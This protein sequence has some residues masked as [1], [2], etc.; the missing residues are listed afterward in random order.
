MPPP[1]PFRRSAEQRPAEPFERSTRGIE[2]QDAGLARKSHPVDVT[3]I[4]SRVNLIGRQDVD[5]AS[6][7][8]RR[9]QVRDR[10]ASPVGIGVEDLSAEHGER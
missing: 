3:A 5:H 7:P 8:V 2:R 10:A 6:E 4:F 9:Q 1:R